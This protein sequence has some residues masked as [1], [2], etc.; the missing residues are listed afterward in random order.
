[1]M[2]PEEEVLF[3]NCVAAN[4]RGRRGFQSQPYAVHGQVSSGMTLSHYFMGVGDH[5]L[6]TQL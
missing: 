4:A 2:S 5:L 3:S 6:P 1:M